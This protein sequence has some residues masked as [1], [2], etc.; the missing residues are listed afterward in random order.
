MTTGKFSSAPSP[1]PSNDSK[2]ESE[3]SEEVL[4]LQKREIEYFKLQ[5]EKNK[6]QRSEMEARRAMLKAQRE[7]IEQ[8][9]AVR[10]AEGELQASFGKDQNGVGIGLTFQGSRAPSRE[11]SVADF[12]TSDLQRKSSLMPRIP[13]SGCQVLDILGCL[14]M[15][16]YCSMSQSSR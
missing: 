2:A 6:A 8:E 10:L 16:I 5:R 15:Y 11:G 12:P 14:C 4:A 13:M 3:L 9:L 7:S 1:N